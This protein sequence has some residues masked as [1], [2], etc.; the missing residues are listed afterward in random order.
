MCR[1]VHMF[2]PTCPFE[3]SSPP[4]FLVTVLVGPSHWVVYTLIQGWL[5]GWVMKRWLAAIKRVREVFHPLECM[6]ATPPLPLLH[7]R[8]KLAA[9]EVKAEAGR[10]ISEL[11]PTTA[12]DLSKLEYPFK[13]PPPVFDYTLSV[14]K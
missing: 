6:S 11:E 12:R 8:V 4:T 5:V 13:A 9:K 1:G 14:S 10:S 3:A 2:W 7:L